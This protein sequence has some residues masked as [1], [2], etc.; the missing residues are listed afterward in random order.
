M[1]AIRQPVARHR[2]EAGFLLVAVVVMCALVL[3]ALSVAAPI[4]AKDLRRDKEVESMHRAQ[5]YVRAIQ[6]YQRACKCKGYPANMDALEKST[7]VRFLRQKYVDP[8]TGH[9]DWRLIHNPQTTIKG[10][11][12]QELGGLSGGLGAAAGMTTGGSGGL[13]GST[14][15]T[16][17]PTS[18]LAS[19]FQGASI[20]NTTPGSNGANGASNTS[21]FGNSSSSTGGMFGDSSGG[22]I[23]G[24]AT[25]KSGDSIL[26]PN[27][28]MTYQ[29]WE[30]WY[31]PRI[32]LL[33]AN[34]NILGGGGPAGSSASGG[35]MSS[36]DSSA[37]GTDIN[38][39]SNK[40]ARTPNGTNNPASPT[41]GTGLGSNSPSFP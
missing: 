33:K 5:Q 25:A 21:T 8:L 22:V 4:I 29:T 37:F 19:G 1:A 41:S 23:Y 34:V 12:G 7:T 10:F 32:E 3:I 17:G 39:N 40:G 18:A 2:G 15:S 27:Q 28:Q 6:L 14:T 36:Q 16:I 35:G 20:T 24:V 31:D 30:F 13:G 38:G 11:F 9:S 26:T